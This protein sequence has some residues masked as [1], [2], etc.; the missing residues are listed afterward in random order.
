MKGTRL[1]SFTSSSRPPNQ[2]ETER[3]RDSFRVTLCNSDS[4]PFLDLGFQFCVALLQ[5]L[6]VV[7]L[8]LPRVA[9]GK[10]IARSLQ[11][12]LV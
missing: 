9:G 7:E 5:S 8:A 12:D 10:S 1:V 6:H 11:G 2:S 4:F 3:P